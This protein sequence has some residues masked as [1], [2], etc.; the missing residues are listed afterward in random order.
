VPEKGAQVSFL[1]NGNG[2]QLDSDEIKQG[3]IFHRLLK[4]T[5]RIC[6]FNYMQIILQL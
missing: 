1:D 2:L 5:L 6:V 3:C 4:C